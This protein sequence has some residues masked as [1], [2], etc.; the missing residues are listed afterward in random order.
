VLSDHVEQDAQVA[1]F[2]LR[3]ER[4]HALQRSAHH[5]HHRL[6][7]LLAQARDHIRV[8]AGEDLVCLELLSPGADRVLMQLVLPSDRSS[9]R[10]VGLGEHLCAEPDARRALLGLGLAH[11][12]AFRLS[13][14][15][16]P[17][18]TQE[19]RPPGQCTTTMPLAGS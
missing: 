4:L 11:E 15:T 10:A 6:A 19:V 7:P 2:D 16:S 8:L 12:R 13:S 9:A 18:R 1:R 3:D 14:H 5:A 17:V